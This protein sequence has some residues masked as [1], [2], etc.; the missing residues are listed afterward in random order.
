[1]KKPNVV[2]LIS[3][4]TGKF[5]SPYGISTVHN[6][7]FEMLAKQSVTFDRCFCTTPLCSPA[8]SALVSGRYPHQNGMNGLPGDTLGGWD[9]QEKDRHLAAVF[10]DNGYKTVLCGG[11]AHET[12]NPFAAGFE[13]QIHEYSDKHKTD[14]IIGSG[15]VIDEWFARNPGIGVDTP[16][17]M[18]IVCGETHRDWDKMAEEYDE[19]G[20][21]KAPYLIDDPEIDRDM[22]YM[23]GASNQLDRGLGEIMGMFEKLGVASDTIFVITTDHGLDFPR[24]KGTLFDPGVEVGLFMRYDNGNWAKG[25]RSDLLISHVDVYPTVLEACGIPVPDGTEGVSLLQA[26]KCPEG[27]APIRDA[28]YLEKTYHDNYDPMRG[29]RTDRYKYVLNFDA[30]T[31]YDVR[32][33]TAP[34]YNWFKYPFQKD[35][36]QELYD[37]ENDPNESVNLAKDPGYADMCMEFKKKLADWM[38]KTNDPLL[39]GAMTSPYHKRISGEMKKLA[40][41]STTHRL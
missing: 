35:S 10:K 37:L 19:E 18:Q 17:Y 4:D 38:K 1:V 3:H 8:R 9:M 5:Y 40:K 22:S 32:I 33:A 27:A 21:W 39:D 2:L 25:K 7:N 16:F 12:T 30:Q 24:A 36:R 11:Y 13:D 14:T 20:V 28:V 34:R 26:I 31:M 41:G 15:E 23:Q 6:P 29:L